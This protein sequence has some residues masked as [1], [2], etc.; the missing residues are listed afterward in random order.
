MALHG[1]VY[2]NGEKLFAWEAVFR[3]T[4]TDTGEDGTET[5]VY[6][7]IYDTVVAYPDKEIRGVTRQRRGDTAEMLAAK[8]VLS[9]AW[10]KKEKPKGRR[11]SAKR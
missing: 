7:D 6:T 4:E 8:V 5:P 3:E 10:G 11:G 2:V 9:A 1:D